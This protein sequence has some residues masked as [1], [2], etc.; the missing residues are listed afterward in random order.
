MLPVDG[1]EVDDGLRV[2]VV[3]DIELV[4]VD[5]S[6]DEACEAERLCGAFEIAEAGACIDFIFV[7]L[8][9][10]VI[11]GEGGVAVDDK[12]GGGMIGEVVANGRG[13]VG[14]G[15]RLCV[16]VESEE[17]AELGGFV[18]EVGVG[19]G[20]EGGCDDGVGDELLKEGDGQKVG[21]GELVDVASEVLGVLVHGAVVGGAF[22]VVGLFG[23]ER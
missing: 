7:F 13:W 9:V 5:K 8:C 23:V 2:L 17:A 12:L 21:P 3:V 22:E 19:L 1:S 14:N 6:D 11:V 4:L 15:C 18:E 20:E 16:V 10:E